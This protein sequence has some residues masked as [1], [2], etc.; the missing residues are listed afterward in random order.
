MDLD[1]HPTSEAQHAFWASGATYRAFVGGIGSGKTW[2]GAAQILLEPPGSVG[3][4]VAPTYPMLRDASQRTFFELAGELVAEHNKAEQRTLLTT[5]TTILWR[6]ADHPDRLRGPNLDWAWGD[7]WAFVSRDA[8]SVLQGRLRRGRGALWLSTTPNGHN[9]L[10]EEIVNGP[11]AADWALFRANTADNTA[12]PEAFIS[13]L[14]R[15]YDAS[16][17][18]Q[19][20]GGEFVDLG[21]H[22]R[23][24]GL[25]LAAVL[26]P[27]PPTPHE[28]AG[29]PVAVYH[30]PQWG[31]RYA[32]GCDPAE[33]L[34]D[35]DDTALCAVEAGSGRV[36]ATVTGKHT[37]EDTARVLGALSA[38]YNDAPALV[39]RNNHG[40]T[41]I[42]HTPAHLLLPGLDGRPG[43]LTTGGSKAAMWSDAH[44]YLRSAAA[45]GLGVVPEPVKAQV[46]AVDRRTLA[47]PEKGKRSAVDDLAVAWALATQA[48]TAPADTAP[49]FPQQAPRPR[50][51]T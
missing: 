29:A 37:P 12:L 44:A 11:G 15:S 10:Y 14:L 40:H 32:I 3:M 41:V 36:C 34:A 45:G 50:R 28:L 43:W 38:F 8:H 47:H 5:G 23:I 35:G 31:V 4:V 24:P 2:A 51:H 17:A 42:S 21:G 26:D 20:L 18:A 48:T 27:T 9:W 33:G 22:K 16:L 39:E 46:G 6:S 30:P 49:S 13:R 7:E 25:L 1:L 19:E